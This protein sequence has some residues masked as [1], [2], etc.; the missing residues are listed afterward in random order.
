MRLGAW[1]C[2][3]KADSLAYKIYGQSTIWTS[4]HRY[5]YNSAYVDALQ[6]SRIESVRVNPDT[7]GW[8]H[9]RIIFFC[10]R[11]SRI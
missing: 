10:W 1:K 4:R 3:L 6:K 2:D 7:V 9:W 8:N 11:A 5:E